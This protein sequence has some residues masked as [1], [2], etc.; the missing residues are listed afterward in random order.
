MNWFSLVVKLPHLG[1]LQT[2]KQTIEK[3]GFPFLFPSYLQ[4]NCLEFKALSLPRR[5]ASVP[6]KDFFPPL[7]V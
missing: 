4:I 6:F 2:S 1:S 3:Y 5:M 7:Y